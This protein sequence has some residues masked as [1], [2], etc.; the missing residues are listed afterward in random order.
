MLCGASSHLHGQA[1]EVRLGLGEA[2]RGR[3]NWDGGEGEGAR[4]G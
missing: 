2:R 1:G 3:S 4:S